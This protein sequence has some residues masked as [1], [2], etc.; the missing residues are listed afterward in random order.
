MLEKSRADYLSQLD[1][2]IV[3]LEPDS[4]QWRTFGSPIR[5]RPL[6]SVILPT[7]LKEDCVQD[8]QNFL[9]SS[10]WY[11]E[12][13]INHQRGY[14]F[15]GPPGTG[16]TSFIKA[17]AGFLNYNIAVLSISSWHMDD[18]RLMTLFANLPPA[19]ML[20]LEDIDAAMVNRSVQTENSQFQGMQGGVTLSGLLNALDG[21]IG[22]DARIVCMSCKIYTITKT[23]FA[24]SNFFYD[25]SHFLRNLIFIFGIA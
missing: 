19:T 11:I 17:L 12:K 24:F 20:L 13:G 10:D 7:E 15:H 6:E 5:K 18:T 4:H 21:I 23:K 16:K 25:G 9:N 8:M 22:G 1:D 2:R 14:L 3:I